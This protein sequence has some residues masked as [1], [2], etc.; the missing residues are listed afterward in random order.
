MPLHRRFTVGA[1]ILLAQLFTH[2]VTNATVNS[3]TCVDLA[4]VLAV[5]GSGSVNTEEFH[6]QQQ[7]IVTA[8]R[9]PA[10][11]QA[12]ERVGSVAAAVMYWGDAEWPVQE[13]GFVLIDDRDDVEQLVTAIE[14]MPRKVL[15]STGLSMGLAAGLDMLE[16]LRCAYRSVINVSGDGSDSIVPRRKRLVPPL[17]EV[18]ARAAA[19][20]V[21]INALVISGK[22]EDLET[23][24]EKQVITGPDAFVMKVGRYNDYAAALRRKLIREIAPVALS[25]N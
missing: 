3:N 21:T 12:M 19:A 22:E 8:L 25:R 4:I 18:R 5:D 20:N 24:F 14:S 16:R 10:V 9:D 13:T 23:Y 15:G 2:S 6:L 7:A 11:Q 17:R 1:A